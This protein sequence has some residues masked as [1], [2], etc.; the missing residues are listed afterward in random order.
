[1][2]L[3]PCKSQKS[4]LPAPPTPNPYPS[5]VFGCSFSVGDGACFLFFYYGWI[6]CEFLMGWDGFNIGLTWVHHGL[7]TNLGRFNRVLHP[8]R[9]WSFEPPDLRHCVVIFLNVATASLLKFRLLS[10]ALS[11]AMSFVISA[12]M[13]KAVFI[14]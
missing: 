1:M 9:N 13:L 4:P 12:R 7:Y 11:G 2:L 3:N 14:C 5:P 10:V 8:D 6:L